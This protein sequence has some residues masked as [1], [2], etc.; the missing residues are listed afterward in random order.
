M[1]RYVT[2]T[3][4]GDMLSTLE[5]YA[6]VEGG[7]CWHVR[8]A[9]GQQV[10]GLPDT[11]ILLPPKWHGARR[12]GTIGFFELKTQRDVLSPV[13][14][15]V[16]AMLGQASEIVSGVIRPQPKSL[17]EITLDDALL[18]LGKAER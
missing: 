13:Q 3:T 18:L 7:Y 1:D 9:R 17:V 4:E 2:S 16:L 11:I 14:R 6:Q 5:G 10:V 12:P 8:D 15:H